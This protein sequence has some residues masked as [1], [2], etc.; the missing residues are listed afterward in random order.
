MELRE[1]EIWR[2]GDLGKG[3]APEARL[4]EGGLGDK[5]RRRME[6]RKNVRSSIKLIRKTK[7]IILKRESVFSGL[8]LV[9]LLIGWVVLLLR[10]VFAHGVCCGDDAGLSFTAKRIDPGKP[11]IYFF[12]FDPHLL[13]LAPVYLGI[14]LLDNLYYIPGLSMVVQSTLLM[15]IIV[16]LLRQ[17]N[18]KL[19]L[20]ITILFFLFSI[21]FCWVSILSNGT[22]RWGR[23]QPV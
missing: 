15:V 7:N 23:C 9:L 11:Q 22:Q 4:G 20:V 6:H 1:E 21:S 2:R 16:L 18:R 17:Y 19:G 5:G 10:L 13:V 14:H 12:G 3:R 8:L